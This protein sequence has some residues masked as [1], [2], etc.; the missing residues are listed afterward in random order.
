MAGDNRTY[1]DED[2]VA[3]FE[4]SVTLMNL[5]SKLKCP[6]CFNSHDSHTTCAE[7]ERKCQMIICENVPKELPPDVVR[8]EL[9]KWF[10]SLT[11]AIISLWKSSSSSSLYC[12]YNSFTIRRDLIPHSL[13]NNF[14]LLETWSCH[15][16][17]CYLLS[18]GNANRESLT[19]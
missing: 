13:L 7:Y 9:S 16:L 8:C 1:Q 15:H 14:C 12:P 5:E 10:H 18:R 11:L 3:V 17:P 6:E 19:N 4:K 2:E